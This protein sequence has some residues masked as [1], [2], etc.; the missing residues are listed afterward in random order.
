M[1]LKVA[2]NPVANPPP[3]PADP[4]PADNPEAFAKAK[5]I[6]TWVLT[7]GFA[8]GAGAVARPKGNLVAVG[9]AAVG[10]LIGWGISR[11][12]HRGSPAEK[13]ALKAASNR[14]L[15]ASDRYTNLSK[16][17][18][19]KN[20]KAQ[21]LALELMKDKSLGGNQ[22]LA[23]AVKL[24]AHPHS[25]VVCRELLDSTEGDVGRN[26]AIQLLTTSS[27]TDAKAIK[28]LSTILKDS[29]DETARLHAATT[30][31]GVEAEAKLVKDT[32]N[33]LMDSTNHELRVMAAMT[34]GISNPKAMHILGSVQASQAASR[35]ST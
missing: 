8:A 9:A 20:A 16:V 30:L 26:A 31:M 27:P 6:L 33:K 13:A 29:K 5:G 28:V 34:A 25:A 22:R 10:G 15:S 32:L 2:E 12:F 18:L 11:L 14:K 19:G 17:N 1:G 21:A 23:L 4:P 7:L 3:T 35:A 24:A